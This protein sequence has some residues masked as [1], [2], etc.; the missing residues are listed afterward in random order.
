MGH[1]ALIMLMAN[2]KMSITTIDINDDYSF[3]A[4]EYLKK[5]F[6]ES[7]INFINGDSIQIL[8]KLKQMKKKF[9][10]FHIDGSHK[11][12]II[13]KEFNYCLNLTSSNI[14]E[15]IFDDEITCR[16]LILNI[17]S[18]FKVLENKVKGYNFETNQYL[19]I[20]LHENRY[21]KIFHYGQFL[22]KNKISYFKLKLNKFINLK[23]I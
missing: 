14:I 2:P 5:K 10:F 15:I 12:K 19:K 20:E 21:L 22:I 6:P 17:L 9:D 1:S 8:K 23:K 13:T 4:T 7:K 3:P 18:T 11:N 16:D